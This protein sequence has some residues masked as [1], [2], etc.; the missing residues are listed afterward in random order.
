MDP[1]VELPLLSDDLA[2]EVAPCC[3][4]EQDPDVQP[5]VTL[6]SRLSMAC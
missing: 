6:R 2:I 5:D 4:A 1:A 3:D